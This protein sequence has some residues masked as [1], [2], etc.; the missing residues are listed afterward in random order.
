[1]QLQGQLLISFVVQNQVVF[2]AE[3]VWIVRIDDSELALLEA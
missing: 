2:R 3:V 1:M